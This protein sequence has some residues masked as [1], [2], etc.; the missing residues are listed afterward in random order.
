M[1]PQASGVKTWQWVVTAIVIIV[2][3]I[4]GIM[5]FGNKSTEA[6]A[7]D[8]S[9]M[10]DSGDSMSQE[11]NR[12]VMTDQYPGNVVHISSVQ[13]SKG[14]WVEIHKDNNGTP[15]EIIGSQWFD[16]GIAPGKIT[17]TKPTVEGGLYYAM[18]HMDDGDKKFDAT[19]DLPLKDSKG[20]VIMKP[21]RASASASAGI[22][23]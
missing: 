7:T 21:F 14:G 8:D 4:I 23:G 3:I 20:A 11:V 5:V 2:L 16:A 17:L 15:G 10:D 1:E 6:P 9:M 22:K 19:K 13:L 12:I 18:L